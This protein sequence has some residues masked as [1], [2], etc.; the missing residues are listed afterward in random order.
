M[1]EN[2]L[3]SA[4]YVEDSFDFVLSTRENSIVVGLSK[5]PDREVYIY[6]ITGRIVVQ[7]TM[8]IGNN[9]IG[10]FKSGIYLVRVQQD[11][12]VKTKKVIV[13]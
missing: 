3:V 5:R 8:E 7:R 12:R 6:D 13:R 9:Q 4:P 10:P 2:Y 11:S 1:L